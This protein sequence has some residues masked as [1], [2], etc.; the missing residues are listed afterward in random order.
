MT[1]SKPSASMWRERTLWTSLGWTW[2]RRSVIE[3]TDMRKAPVGAACGRP[4]LRALDSI[5]RLATL[6]IALPAFAIGDGGRASRSPATGVSPVAIRSGETPDRGGRD[7]RPPGKLVDVGGRNLH[8]YCTGKGA[9]TIVLESGGG[10][11]F[12]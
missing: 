2:I 3:E 1:M 8:L 9:P 5:V 12:A 4:L 10:N 6:T 7:G 11:S